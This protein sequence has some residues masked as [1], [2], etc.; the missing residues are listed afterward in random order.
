M[1][2]GTRA[3][4]SQP[5]TQRST[6]SEPLLGDS[7]PPGELESAADEHVTEHRPPRF[8]SA[9]TRRRR[10]RSCSPEHATVTAAAK[11]PR[12]HSSQ[13]DTTVDEPLELS[14][15]RPSTSVSE[16]EV[17]RLLESVAS[18]RTYVCEQRPSP[19]RFGETLFHLPRSVGYVT[20]YDDYTLITDYD[21]TPF[22][23]LAPRAV[24]PILERRLRYVLH[25][26][27]GNRL[28]VTPELLAARVVGG[29]V[30]GFGYR[31]CSIAGNDC[32]Y[33]AFVPSVNVSL[34]YTH[35][36]PILQLH[37]AYPRQLFVYLSL[38]GIC[39][40]SSGC[41]RWSM[42]TYHQKRVSAASY[43]ARRINWDDVYVMMGDLLQPDDDSGSGPCTVCSQCYACRTSSSRCRRHRV[44]HHRHRE[45]DVS[46][47]TPDVEVGRSFQRN[48]GSAASIR[49]CSR[50]LSA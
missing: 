42:F 28:C 24:R 29:Q 47:D 32:A 17:D 34:R 8:E 23:H 39:R 18:V 44:C 13:E 33:Y 7:Q 31:L 15:N 27:H 37:I 30:V 25:V 50:Y 11:R 5:L 12:R 40:C 38:N 41:L 45:L 20:E 2:T 4:A 3:N 1:N 6:R 10:N 19:L 22:L 48:N 26:S 14:Q 21:F 36:R 46:V 49:P 16:A 35:S 43:C 9:E